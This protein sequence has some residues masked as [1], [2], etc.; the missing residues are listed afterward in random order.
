MEV[1][2]IRFLQMFSKKINGFAKKMCLVLSLTPK[3]LTIWFHE[4][5]K[6]I[7]GILII[8]YY[9]HGIR[10]NKTN[11]THFYRL[12]NSEFSFYFRETLW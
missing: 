2:K 6:Q 8:I 12:V 9:K 10:Q 7:L 1:L 4:K 11:Y 3:L 5:R